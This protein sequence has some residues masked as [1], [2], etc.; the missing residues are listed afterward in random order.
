MRTREILYIFSITRTSF[1]SQGLAVLYVSLAIV[2]FLFC[3]IIS[4][5][6]SLRC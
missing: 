5:F 1:A 3:Q 2:I 6:P 4:E